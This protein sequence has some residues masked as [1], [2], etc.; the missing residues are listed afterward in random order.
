MRPGGQATFGARTFLPFSSGYFQGFCQLLWAL[1]VILL[2]IT[3][4]PVLV[5][6]SGASTVAPPSNL[7]FLVLLLVWLVPYL[8]MGKRIPVEIKPLL[9]FAAVV[10]VTWLAAFFLPIPPFKGQSMFT[11]GPDAFITLA[12][13]MT[14]YIISA[15]WLSLSR[16]KLKITF[17]LIN[18]SGLLVVGWSLLQGYYVFF[19]NNIYP[20]YLYELQS[21]LSSRSVGLFS[22][23]VT[24]MAYEPSWLAH[25]LNLVYLPIWLSATV[26][27]YSSW[28]FRLWRFSIENLL[29]AVGIFTL[30]MSFSRVGWL[31]FF[32]V[33]AFLSVRLNLR[34]AQK[35][36]IWIISRV[37]VPSSLHGLIKS[38]LSFV[39]IIIFLVAYIT[40]LVGLLKIGAS[41]E[42]RLDRFFND[43]FSAGGVYEI[44][45]HLAFA[46][47]VIFWSTGWEIFN[48]HPFLGVGLGNAGFYFPE[49][50][51]AFGWALWEVSQVFYYHGYLPNIKSLWVRIL[52]ETG[53]LGF[54][55]F[56][57]WNYLLWLSGRLAKSV[58]D[59]LMKMA[60]LAGQLV[61][62]AFIVE[63]FSIDS[64][65]LPY[66]WFSA[67]LLSAGAYLARKEI[68]VVVQVGR[69]IDG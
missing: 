46:E 22:D 32:L 69:D 42:P 49:N 9:V 18:I 17:A 44:T 36:Q 61:L 14:V 7:V 65:A 48:D 60:G 11:K 68:G 4:L 43:P 50:M 31:S 25:Q 53:I 63:G 51:P 10:L 39:L 30:M 67:G 34:V 2:P 41:F 54:S 21:I 27:G 29:L 20:H 24:G 66:Y 16:T 5:R 45:N 58:K 40:S 3:S 37:H 62:I 47:R 57:V 35:L 59:P 26:I 64:F 28:R 33:L 8:L 1:G 15:S 12:M 6:I 13:A 55:I 19:N 23:R 56:L 38:S 52:A